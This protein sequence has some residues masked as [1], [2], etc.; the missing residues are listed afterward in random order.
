MF[1]GVGLSINETEAALSPILG[2]L[3]ETYA[4]EILVRKNVTHHG[5]V[6]EWWYD[7][8]L[9]SNSMK[10]TVCLG[11]SIWTQTRRL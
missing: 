3:N 11:W 2:H 9:Y 5:T 7:L 4:D 1:G 10:L 8:G 6:Y